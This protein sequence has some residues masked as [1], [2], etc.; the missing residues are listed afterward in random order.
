MVI[1]YVFEHEYL[2]LIYVLFV[3]RFNEHTLGEGN[4]L[5]PQSSEPF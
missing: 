4:G 2:L 5:Y 1:D 3:C